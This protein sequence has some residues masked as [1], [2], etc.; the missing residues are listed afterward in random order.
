MKTHEIYKITYEITWKLYV[1][2]KYSLLL[3]SES[4]FQ[5]LYFLSI[6]FLHYYFNIILKK[7]GMQQD[8]VIW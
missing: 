8:N 5:K 2:C 6:V 1:L 3:A 4:D 7:Y